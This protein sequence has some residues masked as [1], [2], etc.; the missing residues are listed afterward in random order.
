M[1]A[2]P[3]D[4]DGPVDEVGVDL[5][6]DEARGLLDGWTA[7][8]GTGDRTGERTGALG[9]DRDAAHARLAALTEAEALLRSAL[10]EDGEVTLEPLL[11]APDPL[12]LADGLPPPALAPAPDGLSEV[13][14]VAQHPFWAERGAEP[15]GRPTDA[16]FVDLDDR[17][18]ALGGGGRTQPG[19]SLDGDRPTD[20][21][22]TDP[23][24]RTL[25]RLP[26][27]APAGPPRW[28]LFVLGAMV[29]VLGGAVV[30]L[31]AR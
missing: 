23:S 9:T 11:G 25:T 30:L 17:T 12:P 8:G 22:F 24:E 3:P 20:G 1:S 14:A 27:P 19:V 26:V 13:T 7:T 28:L 5:G 4:G 31:L 10:V 15:E 18:D 16:G 21:G 6:P 2:D 29:V